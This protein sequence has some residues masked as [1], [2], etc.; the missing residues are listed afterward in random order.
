MYGVQLIIASHPGKESVEP[1]KRSAWEDWVL[2][3]LG[4]LVLVLL[5]LGA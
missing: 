3:L 1:P 2:V 5:G 4:V